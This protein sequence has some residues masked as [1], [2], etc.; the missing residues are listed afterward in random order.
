MKKEKLRLL[1]LPLIF[2]T[3]CL[4]CFSGAFYTTQMLPDQYAYRRWQG[5]GTLPFSQISCFLPGEKKISL[6]DVY[7]FRNAMMTAFRTDSIESENPY[8]FLDCWST[9]GS[10]RVYGDRNS[11]TASLQ[12]VGGNFFVFHPLKLVN[13]SYFS[14]T[15]LMQDNILLDEDLAWL[16]FGGNDL[17]GMTVHLLD[18][19]FRIAGVVARGNDYASRKAY[20]AGM[21]LYMSYD[22]FLSIS[23][24]D[25]G[26]GITCY[27]ACIPNPVK[28]YAKKLADEK[29]PIGTGLILENTHR[30]SFWNLLRI[31]KDLPARSIHDGPSLPYWE[32]AARYAETSAA[33]LLLVGLLTGLVPLV[34]AVRLL[35]TGGRKAK[36]KLEDEVLP[37]W[38][39]RAEEAVRVQQRRRWEKRQERNK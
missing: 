10:I 37:A 12:A 9:P 25:A 33:L 11:G 27:E 22:A 5:D 18:V 7:T 28:G 3:V 34:A 2:L 39:E 15:D 31:V 35:L 13:G 21:G 20:T 26:I 38:G 32:N 30:F 8:P 24:E 1:I 6:T 16:L 14:E 36:E 23:A 19:P 4:A 17:E 29:F